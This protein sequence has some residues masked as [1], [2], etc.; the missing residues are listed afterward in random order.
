M[1]PVTEAIDEPLTRGHKK[2]ARTRRALLDAALEVLAEQGDGFSVVDVAAR[3]GVSHG[4]FY[5]YFADREAL[6]AALVPVLIEAF[7]ARA[8]AEV[9]EA[10]AA[11]RF[12]VITARALAVAAEAPDLV[13]AALRLEAV[14]RALLVEGPLAYLR[15][16]LT[17]GLAAGRFDGPVDDGTLD[18]VVGAL[19]LT[20]RRIVDGEAGLDHRRSVIGRLLASLGVPA[21]EA[22][23]LAARAVA[24]S[25]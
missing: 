13:R 16:D 10:D 22:A 17:A 19:L 12:A 14:Q 3:A 15:D 21:D 4:T 6:V 5:N 7:A 2:K 11:A 24:R 18:V 8:A 1:I 23:V 9:D 20:A 25:G